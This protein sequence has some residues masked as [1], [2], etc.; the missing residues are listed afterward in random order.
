MIAGWLLPGVLLEF[1]ILMF[2]WFRR[3]HHMRIFLMIPAV[4]GLFA[5][6]MALLSFVVLLAEGPMAIAPEAATLLNAAFVVLGFTIFAI[7]RVPTGMATAAG[8]QS[9]HLL[10]AGDSERKRP[11]ILDLLGCVGVAMLALA[12]VIAF[13]GLVVVYGK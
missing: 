8:G 5:L 4:F 6:L 9:A 12:A 11:M 2:M 10:G 1:A 7:P 3:I 13:T